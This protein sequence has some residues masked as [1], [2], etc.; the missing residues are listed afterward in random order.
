MTDYRMMYDNPYLAFYDLEGKDLVLT[1][2]KVVK[3]S[4]RDMISGEMKS[5]PIVSFSETTKKLIVNKTNGRT[6]MSMY[7]RD[8][9]GWVGKKVAVFAT[10][11][12]G[13][14]CLRIRSQV[15]Q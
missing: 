13:K 12:K 4:V 1:V 15:P 6:L 2:T 8:D 10:K 11:D 7:G 3:G 14:D 9:A 5:Y